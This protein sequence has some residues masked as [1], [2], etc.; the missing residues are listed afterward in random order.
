MKSIKK[1]KKLTLFRVTASRMGAWR[2]SQYL[3]GMHYGRDKSNPVG[4]ASWRRGPRGAH[5]VAVACDEPTL[6]LAC[7]AVARVA[8]TLGFA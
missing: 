2:A 3:R 4:V 1:N 8:L 7:M 5:G 6:G